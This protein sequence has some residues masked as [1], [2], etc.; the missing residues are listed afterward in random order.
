MLLFS[1]I[2]IIIIT[3]SYWCIRR[4]NFWKYRN[5][6]YISSIP[7]LGHFCGPVLLWENITTTLDYLYNHPNAKNKPFVGVFFF[8]KPAILVRDIELAKRILITDFNSFSDRHTGADPKVDPIGGNNL[9]QMKNP[10]WRILRSKLSPLFTSGKMKQMF[11]MVENVTKDLKVK[12][13]NDGIQD[14]RELFSCFTVDVIS[15][16]AFGTEANC[17]KNPETSEFLQNAKKS[18]LSSTWSKICFNSVFFLPEIYAFFK[19]TTFDPDFGEFLRRLFNEV[20]KNRI[21]SGSN[22]NDLIDAL[23]MIQKME[24]DN[25]C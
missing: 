15:L 25:S 8:H 13:Q 6:P 10:T 21:T 17:L 3:L 4:N 23:S 20:S 9:F 24:V 14:A 16:V 5:I 22:R 7:I 1:L 12:I 19:M 2:L 18:L 11:Y